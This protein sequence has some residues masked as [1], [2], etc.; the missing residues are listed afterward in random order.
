MSYALDVLFCDEGWIVLHIVRGLAPRRITRWVTGC[1]YVVELQAGVLPL[2][3]S[4][5]TRL[6]LSPVADAGRP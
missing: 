5:G 3:L 6:E 2:D 4:V 1:R